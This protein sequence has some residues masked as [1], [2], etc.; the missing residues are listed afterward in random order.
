MHCVLNAITLAY[1]LPYV[2]VR[3]RPLASQQNDEV[4][5]VMSGGFES[6]Q[7]KKDLLAAASGSSFQV[8]PNKVWMEGYL[9]KKGNSKGPLSKD[10]WSRRYFVLKV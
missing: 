9:T 1:N 10:P 8:N 6:N 5:S 2:L 3:D 7:S 4:E